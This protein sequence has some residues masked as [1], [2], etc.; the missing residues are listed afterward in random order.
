MSGAPRPRPAPRTADRGSCAAGGRV[1]ARPRSAAPAGGAITR[2][3]L[4][5]TVPPAV[6]LPHRLRVSRMASLAGRRP[7]C[8]GDR[9]SPRRQAAAAPRPAA[10]PTR[11]AAGT[12]G[13]PP[14]GSRRPRSRRRR[15]PPGMW[16]M[17]V[18]LAADR[19]G[20]PIGEPE[21]RRQG[22]E[23]AAHPPGIVRQ[24]AQPGGARRPGRQRHDHGRRPGID[25][26]ADPAGA[27]VA[28]PHHLRR[29]VRQL[30][31]LGSGNRHDG[32]LARCQSRHQPFTPLGASAAVSAERGRASPPGAGPAG[33]TSPR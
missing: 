24:Q 31:R 19:H 7:V 25:P 32:S 18:R 14:H 8:C 21:H 26:Q 29:A 3:Q 11:G 33:R 5:I 1:R 30:N 27:G 20:G 13:P 10:G 2:R 16:R 22:G 23:L 4:N 28:P 12:P 9:P 6:Q 17:Q 15:G